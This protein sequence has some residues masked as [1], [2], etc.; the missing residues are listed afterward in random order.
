MT[1]WTLGSLDGRL[2]EIDDLLFKDDT[3]QVAIDPTDRRILEVEAQAI[4]ETTSEELGKHWQKDASHF[5]EM[6]QKVRNINRVAAMVERHMKLRPEPN[7][8]NDKIIESAF[9]ALRDGSK[10][11]DEVAKEIYSIFSY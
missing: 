7:P 1:Q 6:R 5:Y 4:L 3:G 10:T 11:N 8:E 9:K 2:T